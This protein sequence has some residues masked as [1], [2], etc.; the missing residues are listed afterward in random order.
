MEAYMHTTPLPEVGEPKLR[1]CGPNGCVRFGVAG[2][3]HDIIALNQRFIRLPNPGENIIGGQI[4]WIVM[5]FGDGP[6]ARLIRCSCLAVVAGSDFVVGR[7]G[8]L[9]A[10]DQRVMRAYLSANRPPRVFP[11]ELAQAS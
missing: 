7:F 10:A 4:F 2:E 5:R 1:R 3:E 9:S 6:L 8:E 11:Q